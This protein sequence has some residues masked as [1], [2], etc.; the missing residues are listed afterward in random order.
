M[1]KI[2]LALLSCIAGAVMFTS[3]SKS[4]SSVA[5][6]LFQ[7]GQ[8]LST[9][10][11]LCG[12]I[13]GT[14][15][16]D[17]TYN[18]T[19]PITVNAGDTLLIQ[20]GVTINIMH[21]TD[22][23]I[24]ISVQGVLVSAGIKT[25]PIKFT[26]PGA[27][28]TDDASV[29]PS[30]DSAYIGRWVGI[31]CDTSCPLLVLKWTHL[32]FGGM[33]Y[34]AAP[35]P[36]AQTGKDILF[37]T[38]TGTFVMEDSW[39][40]G[41]VDDPIRLQGGKVHMMRNTIEKT[42]PSGGDAFNAKHGTVGVMAYNLFIGCATNGT[43]ASDKGTYTG[44]VCQIDMYNNTYVN[45]GY[46]Q[47][48][49]GRGACINYEQ[50]AFGQYY[51]NLMVNC[52]FGPRVVPNP[53]A[54]TADMHY[55][56]SFQYG[57][58]D[59]IV[60]QFYPVGYVTHPQTTDIPSPATLIANYSAYVLGATYVGTSQTKMNNPNFVGYTLP[61]A[62][63]YL[64]TYTAGNNFHLNTG[65]PCLGK[66]YTSWTPFNQVAVSTTTPYGATE[67]TPP[68]KDIGC[69]QADGTGNQH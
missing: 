21:R 4:S 15:K 1:K 58:A 23:P 49:A 16:A 67:I 35:F 46:R 11:P 65:S 54:D 14:M 37:Q 32:E 9:G 55:G 43:K 6:K 44:P 38:P 30:V 19:C 17:S 56:Y 33:T 8:T 41:G 48:Q 12:A 69:Y 22:T 64:V 51:N 26:V 29:S 36:L 57:D 7:V 5:A 39:I 68:G 28:K 45:C 53:A 42:G 52:R 60:N 13:K 18:V 10:K 25:D 31:L 27:V 20:Q 62:N 66:G 24:Y 2:Q 59:S 63:G 47:V 3:C 34:L 50:G 40:Y 61:A